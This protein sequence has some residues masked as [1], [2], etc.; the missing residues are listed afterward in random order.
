MKKLFAVIGISAMM[1]FVS[2]RD[3]PDKQDQDN[4][5][6]SEDSVEIEK[7]DT[8]LSN[9]TISFFDQSGLSKFTKTKSPGFDWS[10]FKMTN[11][12]QDDSLLI[13]DFRPSINFY[14]SYKTLLKYSPDS[15]MFID[16][17]SYNLDVHRESNGKIIAIE[18]GPDTEVSLVDVKS[19]KK[20]RLVFLG[21]GN[22][23]EEGSWIDK[24][25]LV[26]MGFQDNDGS[27]N[28]IPVVW[29]YHVPAKTFYIYELPDPKA[30]KQLMGQWRRERLRGVMLK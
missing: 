18:A 25:N 3:T 14:D 8:A 6:T 22:S 12:W 26:L 28:Q 4:E 27:G 20:T 16:L 17:D 2:C 15:S 19:K 21:P 10:K 7:A 23:I 5:T 9:E 11:T 30:A 29:R 13:T 24:E 1:I